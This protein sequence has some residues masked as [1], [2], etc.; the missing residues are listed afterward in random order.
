MLAD[1][2]FM[3]AELAVWSSQVSRYTGRQAGKRCVDP[4]IQLLSFRAKANRRRAT[5]EG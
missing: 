4:R 1:E 3:S 5:T 2:P